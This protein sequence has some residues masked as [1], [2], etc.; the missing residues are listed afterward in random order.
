M[1]KPKFRFT[2]LCEDKNHY[3]FIKSYLECKYSSGH[4][5]FRPKISPEGKGSAEQYVRDNFAEEVKNHR[6]YGNVLIVVTDAD[7]YTFDERLQ[8]LNQTLTKNL[9]KQLSKDDKIIVLIP[10]RNIETWFRYA[11]NPEDCNENK[12]YKQ[13]YDEEVT[14]KQYGAKYAKGNIFCNGS[15][16][17]LQKACKELN[18]LKKLLS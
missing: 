15:L 5:S 14:P 2:V 4:G 18:R 11:D 7:N 12:D 16:K 17:A 1:S 8:T 6:K 10:A 9:Y 3:Y 13:E